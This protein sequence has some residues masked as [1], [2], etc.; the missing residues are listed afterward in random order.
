MQKHFNIHFGIED[1]P[2]SMRD[3][4]KSEDSIVLVDDV[5]DAF[6]ENNGYVLNIKSQRSIPI[7]V[8]GFIEDSTLILKQYFYRFPK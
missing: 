7:Y 8:R 2:I 5:F 3:F 4:D 6:E 1:R